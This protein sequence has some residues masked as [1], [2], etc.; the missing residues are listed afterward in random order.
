MNTLNETVTPA[1]APVSAPRLTS[2]FLSLC[3]AH[4]VIEYKQLQTILSPISYRWPRLHPDAHGNENAADHFFHY[5]GNRLEEDLKQPVEKLNEGTRLYFYRE[6]LLNFAEQADVQKDRFEQLRT[7]LQH[8]EETS[9]KPAETKKALQ[10]LDALQTQ[11]VLLSRSIRSA[12]L[13]PPAV[14]TRPDS[15]T[16]EQT[17]IA[18]EKKS[19]LKIPQ[20]PPLKIKKKPAL[21][22]GKEPTLTE[23]E[24][25]Y[26]TLTESFHKIR[27]ALNEVEQD[28]HAL[29]PTQREGYTESHTD[30]AWFEHYYS[31]VLGI[32]SLAITCHD[33]G[34]AYT[35]VLEQFMESYREK[36]QEFYTLS[37]TLDAYCQKTPNE[38]LQS[39]IQELENL[40]DTT[41]AFIQHMQVKAQRNIAR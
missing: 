16:P 15:E 22:I 33:R 26:D 19:V 25:A 14:R 6:P 24:T 17:D 36:H 4:M 1:L 2:S 11:T 30:A 3:Y 28:P 18:P 29:P 13:E 10:A 21:K 27:T 23:M 41:R 37:N 34:F 7:Q 40:D 12:D 31:A 20:Q 5:M 9:L 38:E 32:L 35:P 8:P 39:V